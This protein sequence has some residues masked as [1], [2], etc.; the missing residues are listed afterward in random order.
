MIYPTEY[1]F[2]FNT[3]SSELQTPLLVSID[4][5]K[6]GTP[7]LLFTTP[8]KEWTLLCTRQVVCSDTRK[9]FSLNYSEIKSFLAKDLKKANRSK[10]NLPIRIKSEW[11]ELA[12]ID[13]YN[14]EKILHANHGKDFFALW[15]I[16]LM[17]FRISE[18]SDDSVHNISDKGPS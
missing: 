8:T 4:L 7:V 9:V 15:N 12:V 11:N 5:E 2:F 10:L 16:I 14:A 1:A 17:M 6:S 13:K 18:D 3:L